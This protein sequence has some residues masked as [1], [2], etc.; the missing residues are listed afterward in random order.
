[1]HMHVGRIRGAMLHHISMEYQPSINTW[2]INLAG[3]TLT[4]IWPM[5]NC[6]SYYKLTKGKV[7]EYSK[8]LDNSKYGWYFTK[9]SSL[10][11]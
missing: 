6:I 4:R 1:M 8:I 2:H 9:G 7:D 5:V 3:S 11:F 10:L